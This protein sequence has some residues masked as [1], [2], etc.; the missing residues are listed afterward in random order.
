MPTCQKGAIFNIR[1]GRLVTGNKHFSTSRGIPSKLLATSTD[2]GDIDTIFGVTDE[3][4]FWDNAAFDGGTAK[5]CADPNGGIRAVFKGTPP[6][7]CATVA[8]RTLAGMF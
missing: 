2:I 5:F 7:D 1:E 8:L 3:S 6:A 4:L